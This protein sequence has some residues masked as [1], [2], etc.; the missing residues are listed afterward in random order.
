MLFPFLCPLPK[1]L[2]FPPPPP[3]P[4][5]SPTHP[6]PLHGPGISLLLGHRA[7]TGPWAS[8]PIDDRVGHPMLHMQLEPWV[9]PCVAF[10]WWLSPW[11]H[12]GYW[13]VHIGVPPM[14]LQTPSAPCVLLLALLWG[15]CAPSCGW[16]WA[17]TS[18]FVRYWQ[19]LSFWKVLWFCNFVLR[20]VL[21]ACSI[22]DSPSVS[23]G[24]F[25]NC[26]YN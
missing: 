6:L 10:G 23:A 4:P 8:P 25:W 24:M 17:S 26:F 3:I 13:L 2:S 7:F 16:L 5:R 21:R 11:E 14:G 9:P 22:I 18:V 1:A 20:H 12:W 15:S 19:S